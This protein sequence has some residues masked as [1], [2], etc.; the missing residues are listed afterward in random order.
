V[1]TK[2]RAEI[3]VFGGSGFYSLLSD[4]REIALDTPYGAPSDRLAIG[5]LAG[6]R[7]AF[8][9]R[10]GRQHQLPPHLLNFRANMWAM[11]EL[12][13]GRVI[14]PSACGSLKPSVKPGEM[15]VSDQLLNFT[16]GRRDTYF[17]GPIA[18]HVS[19]ADPYCPQLRSIANAALGKLGFPAHDTGTVVV[20]N[21]PRFSTRAESRF[22]SSIGGDVIN[23]TQYPEAYLARELEMCYV[24]IALVT[25]YDVG[26]EGDLDLKPV[27]TEEVI[28]V[29]ARH[30]D[31]VRTA[32]GEIIAHIPAEYACECHEALSRARL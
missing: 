9:P 25:D 21:G 12:G 24:N 22:F 2:E 29:L 32:I 20:V 30:N 23:M 7:V 10:H 13:V 26:L 27:S 11:K 5:E 14:G 3:G 8:L 28:Q 17:D 19:F 4:A 6:K 15:V 18:T 31:R 1:A 16:S